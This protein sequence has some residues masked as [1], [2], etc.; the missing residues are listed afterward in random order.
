MD[1]EF[2]TSDP[3]AYIRARIRSLLT[4]GVPK[5]GGDIS[6]EFTRLLGPSAIHFGS[7]DERVHRLQAAVDAFA[8]RHQVA[9]TLIRFLHVVLHHQ[10]GKS[11]WVELTVRTFWN[12]HRHD[13]V[14]DGSQGDGGHW[15]DATTREV[16]PASQCG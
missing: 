6:G 5:S 16:A 9:E 15:H 1:D 4:E 2:F 12:P 14:R 7:V 10:D 11:Y 13:S 3:Y 8:L